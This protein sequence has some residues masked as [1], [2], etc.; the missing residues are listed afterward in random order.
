M[1]VVL[2][3]VPVMID[4]PL[5]DEPPVMLPVVA[6]TDQLYV[7]PAGTMPLIISVGVTVNNTPLQLTVLIAVTAGVGLIVTVNEKLAPKQ[8]PV[9]GVTI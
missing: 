8:L 4:T 6:G 3:N 9:T 2:A 5:A 1:F 7:V